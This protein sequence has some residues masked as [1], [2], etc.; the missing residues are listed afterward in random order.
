MKFK[1]FLA[2]LVLKIPWRNL[3]KEPV[4]ATVEGLYVLLVPNQGNI[5]ALI[6]RYI[7]NVDKKN[8]KRNQSAMS[9]INFCRKILS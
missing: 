7:F 4:E 8:K 1:T 3:Y 6:S 5:C 9:I 2:N